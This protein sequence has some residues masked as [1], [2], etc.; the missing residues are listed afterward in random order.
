MLVLSLVVLTYTAFFTLFNTLLDGS[1]YIVHD[2]KMEGVILAAVQVF[3][4][5][6]CPLAG[7][8]AAVHIGRYKVMCYSLW[9]MWIGTFGGSIGLIFFFS[10][11]SYHLIWY[12]VFI[13]AV[14][15]IAGGFAAFSV[16]A[17]QFGV[18]QMPD[19]SVDD[20][21]CFIRWYTWAFFS[22][23]GIASVGELVLK[24]VDKH[25]EPYILLSLVPMVALSLAMCCSFLLGGWLTIEPK[26]QNP[27]KTVHQV[28]RFAVKHKRP[29]RRSA[30]TFCEDE[31]PSRIDLAKTKYGGPFSTEQVE[32][33]KTCLRVI[34]VLI[35][36]SL[37]EL[38]RWSYTFSTT[39][40]GSECYQHALL[41][42]Y[43]TP[44]FVMVTIPLYEALLHPFF[45]RC[46]PSSFT[47]IGIS[48]TLAV[49][50]S[51]I[52]LAQQAAEH[53]GGCILETAYNE[54]NYLWVDVPTKLL[55]SLHTVMFTIALFQ[56]IC[57]QSPY[58]LRGILTGLAYSIPFF[59]LP[60]G[61]TFYLVWTLVWKENQSRPTCG[62]WYYLAQVLVALVTLLVWCV[63]ARWY[64]WRQRE[65]P[66]NER[67][68]VEEVYERYCVQINN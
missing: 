6:C 21:C 67:V 24:C 20:I 52:P 43:S 4:V 45:R 55:I 2:R 11:L 13:P 50:F 30:F 7:W 58:A 15:L 26:E 63:A 38:P 19:G 65:E 41:L 51:L 56:F 49:V 25:N 60:L 48:A 27:L 46:N 1:Y 40:F 62:T 17:L 44:V 59:G 3:V 61:N 23:E 33:V 39:N 22:G 9:M 31:R 28:L 34:L 54:K 8:L 42:S 64:K 36:I 18:D 47:R 5:L 37:I 35:C 53:S 29:I 14:V 12:C 32:D 10:P 68:F 57:S 16:N 66:A